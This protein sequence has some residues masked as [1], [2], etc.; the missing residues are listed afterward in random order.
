MCCCPGPPLSRLYFNRYQHKAVYCL[1]LPEYASLRLTKGEDGCSE[2]S[3]PIW[4]PWMKHLDPCRF[5]SVQG[6]TP[7]FSP[8]SSIQ[9]SL[10]VSVD[11]VHHPPPTQLAARLMGQEQGKLPSCSF[12]SKYKLAWGIGELKVGGGTNPPQLP[13]GKIL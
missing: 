7:W 6:L 4:N 11:C 2:G 8:L 13:R 5:L 10:T 12:I 9:G 3:S 1:S